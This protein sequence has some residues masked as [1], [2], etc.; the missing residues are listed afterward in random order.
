LG[1]IDVRAAGQPKRL[2]GESDVL[3]ERIA[4][5]VGSAG[6]DAHHDALHRGNL[7]IVVA[8][9]VMPMAIREIEF[10][11]IA[12]VPLPVALLVRAFCRFRRTSTMRFI[13]IIWASA[14]SRK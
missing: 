6:P 9:V 2:A 3:A 12:P 13:A 5:G 10:A 7:G 11:G 8:R 1:P 14:L 4:F